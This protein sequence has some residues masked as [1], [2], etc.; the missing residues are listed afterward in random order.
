MPPFRRP[1]NGGPA[2]RP[3]S[4]A[5]SSGADLNDVAVQGYLRWL[6]NRALA[7]YTTC[8]ATGYS[9][10][11]VFSGLLTEASWRLTLLLPAPIALIALLGGSDAGGLRGPL[12]AG[13]DTESTCST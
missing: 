7:I 11:L 1:S 8:G 5:A 9:M 4:S 2:W 10:G 12:G 3:A 6:R 13:T